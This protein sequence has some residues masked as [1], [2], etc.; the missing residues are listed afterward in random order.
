MEGVVIS[1][2]ATA[3]T[4]VTMDGSNKTPKIEGNYYI[5][6]ATEATL[7]T[8]GG[9]Q[10]WKQ[11]TGYIQADGKERTISVDLTEYEGMKVKVTFNCGSKQEG[12]QLQVAGDAST[13]QDVTFNADKQ[14]A[15]VDVSF[16]VDGGSIASFEN[17]NQAVRFYSVTIEVVE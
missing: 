17:T 8:I 3:S 9:D 16:T 7:V 2:S 15:P 10:Q 4:A 11:G 12:I 6:N 5:W 14:Y 1:T 13:A